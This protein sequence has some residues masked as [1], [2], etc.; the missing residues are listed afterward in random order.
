[1]AM[2]GE[3]ILALTGKR[4]SGQS[5]RTQNGEFMKFIGFYKIWLKLPNGVIIGR[6]DAKYHLGKCLFLVT[7]AVAIANIVKSSLGPVGLDKMLVDD[8]GVRNLEDF[9]WWPMINLKIGGTIAFFN[10]RSNRNFWKTLSETFCS[11]YPQSTHTHLSNH[12]LLF[13]PISLLY[14]LLKMWTVQ[15]SGCGWSEQKAIFWSFFFHRE[16]TKYWISVT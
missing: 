1:M 6:F 16:Q 3:G 2:A 5:I 12:P 8:V 7:A 9:S 14:S 4:T 15:T 13:S 11:T 10:L